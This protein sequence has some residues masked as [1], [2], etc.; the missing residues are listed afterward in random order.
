MFRG[1][2]AQ[3][4]LDL[5]PGES[6]VFVAQSCLTL[7]DSM[8][9][10]LSGSSVLGVLQARIV[11]W[12]AF[13]FSRESSQPSSRQGLPHCT[14][15]LYHLSHQGSPMSGGLGLNLSSVLS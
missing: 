14:Q 11:M 9:C 1:N 7:C 4:T 12:D 15:I 8:D 13:P 5:I 3:R 6:E 10:S 2:R